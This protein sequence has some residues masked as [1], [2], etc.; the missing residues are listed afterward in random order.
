MRKPLRFFI[1][2]FA[3]FFIP[4]LLYA[5]KD[6]LFWFVAPEATSAHGDAPI[7]FRLSS[8]GGSADVTI[9]QPAN[10][11]FTPISVT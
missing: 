6:T 2:S 9:D 1:Y 11:G 8:F 5:Q 7:Y 4:C 10:P 3:I